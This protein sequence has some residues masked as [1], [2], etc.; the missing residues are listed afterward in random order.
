MSGRTCWCRTSCSGLMTEDRSA[1]GTRGRIRPTPA[2]DR[3]MLV[4]MPGADR[5]SRI[6][7]VAAARAGTECHV[8][9][10]WR[11]ACLWVIATQTQPVGPAKSDDDPARRRHADRDGVRVLA[12][13]ISRRVERARSD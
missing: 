6:E 9:A 7:R 5:E 1:K 13:D 3:A 11:D 4:A 8:K 10:V 2:Y 12:K